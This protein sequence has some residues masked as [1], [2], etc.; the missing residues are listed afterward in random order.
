MTFELRYDQKCNCIIGSFIGNMN[1]EAIKEYAKEIKKTVSKYNCKHFFNDLRGANI[2]LSITD[3]YYI[4]NLLI[5][6]GIDRRWRIA[7]VILKESED[8]S[9]F[10]T[11]ALNRRFRVKV[12]T[13]PNEAMIW[14]KGR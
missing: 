9:F 10:E 13:D 5:Q 1:L 12:F 14:L 7:I 3:I 6:F 4:P 11:V 8:S 2:N